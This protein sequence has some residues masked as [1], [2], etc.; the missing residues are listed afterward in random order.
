[1]EQIELTKVKIVGRLREDLGDLEPL[2]KS[3]SLRG[4]Y[5]PILLDEDNALLAGGRRCAAAGELGWKTIGYTRRGKVS[6]L[7]SK[8]IELEEN[9]DGIRKS[10]TAQEEVVALLDIHKKKQDELGA[11]K[12]GTS[13]GWSLVDTASML[14]ISTA[15]ASMYCSVAKIISD[16]KN[17]KREEVASALKS[18]G[19]VEAYKL[20]K[21]HEE[22]QIASQLSAL[23]EQQ[24]TQA[25]KVVSKEGAASVFAATAKLVDKMWFYSDC[26]KHV[27]TLTDGTIGLVHTDPPYAIEADKVKRD[28][29]VD[30]YKNDTKK[31]FTDIWQLLPK[32]L[33]RVTKSDAFCFVWCSWAMNEFLITSMQIAGW[34]VHPLPYIWVRLGSGGQC[35]MPD[36]YLASCCDF[37]FVFSKGEAHLIKQGRP[38]YSLEHA[39]SD[40]QKTHPL[41]R[42]VPLVAE[43]LETFALPGSLV[44]DPF[45]GG[46]S[47][48]KACLATNMF[49]ISCEL[50]KGYYDRTR[51]ELIY[52]LGGPQEVIQPIKNLSE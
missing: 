43:L 14:G 5:Q 13:G 12:T 18:F 31:A 1:M 49:G 4:Q 46:G 19:I 40:N 11:S 32:E 52:M 28:N 22:Q 10:M 27:K 47:T 23:V 20:I 26:L 9:L 6:A 7:D 2:K 41:E 39:L 25:I 37:G 15:K 51:M 42:P 30:M 33:F 38:N 16:E 50:D 17:E 48:L 21:F 8:I 35:N 36:R 24:K 3:M 45:G 34:Q 44:Y 29:S